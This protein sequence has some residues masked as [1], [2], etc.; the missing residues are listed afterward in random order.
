MMVYGL[1]CQGSMR[2]N[3]LLLLL[4]SSLSIHSIQNMLNLISGSTLFFVTLPSSPILYSLI[5]QNQH[6]S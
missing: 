2:Y 5:Y 3:L 4:V 1:T 6:L